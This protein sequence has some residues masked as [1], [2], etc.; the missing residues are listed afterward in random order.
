[1]TWA[2][3]MLLLIVFRGIGA[4][5]QAPAWQVAMMSAQTNESSSRINAT[6]ADAAGNV[7]VA[8]SFWGTVRLGS[9]EL[10]S[11]GGSDVFVAKWSGALGK[12]VWAQ[13]AGGS[14][15]DHSASLALH[16]DAVYV[17][18]QFGGT[19]AE[20]ASAPATATFGTTTLT[21]A[22]G[23]DAFVAKLSDHGTAAAFVW[24]ARAGG[25][26]NDRATALAANANTLYLGG[27][28]TQAAQFGSTTLATTGQTATSPDIFVA[29][30]TDTGPAA[31]FGWAQQAGGSGYDSGPLLAVSGSGV[32][33]AGHFSGS[34]SF[35]PTSLTAKGLSNVFIAKLADLGAT[36]RF[37][38]CQR[39]GSDGLD[40]VRALAVRGKSVYLAGYF[41]GNVATFGALALTNADQHVYLPDS[42]NPKSGIVCGPRRSTGTFGSDAFVAKLTD[43]G[44]SGRFVWAERAGGLGDDGVYAMAV[45]GTEVYVAGFFGHRHDRKQHLPAA[46]ASFGRTALSSVGQTDGFVAKLTDTG[47]AAGFTWAQGVGGPHDDDALTLAVAGPK[48]WLSGELAKTS[49]SRFGHQPAA[50]PAGLT[51]RSSFLAVLTPAL[52]A[53]APRPT[54]PGK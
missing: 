24:A 3:L 54:T 36:S 7:Y 15:F 4:F 41:G 35:G 34:V 43:T 27:L 51:D 9:T 16:R 21:S 11:A 31:R 52:L 39:V 53:S 33:V 45:Q 6:V 26:G 29:K 50:L 42:S 25:A 38:W 14:G 44:A 12:Y 28:F 32:Y 22:G 40:Y 17:V 5:A 2:R 37:G 18:G 19:A 10:N 20:T 49:G 48:V 46:P 1:M 8:G 30:L 47:P 23:S 13:R